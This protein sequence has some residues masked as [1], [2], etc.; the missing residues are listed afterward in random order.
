MTAP[1]P[2]T[3]FPTQGAA[4]RTDFD[5]AD[6][7]PVLNLLSAYSLAYNTFD[8]DGWFDLF[9]EDVTF[10]VGVPGMEP[11]AQ[12][13]DEFRSFWRTRMGDFQSQGLQRRHLVSNV[14]FLD[15]DATSAHVSVVGL[16]TNTVDGKEFQ[17]VANLNYE[18]WLEKRNGVWKI[19]RWH[20]FPD[21]PVS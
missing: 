3:T 12:H 15:E 2:L 5:V 1:H 16:L 13:G 20:D 18:G 8:A 9:T 10:V 4:G 17:P 11:I 6:R 14:V 21:S 19:A 7:L